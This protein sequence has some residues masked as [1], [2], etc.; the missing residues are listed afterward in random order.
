MDIH[1]PHGGDGSDD[2]ND[3]SGSGGGGG[4]ELTDDVPSLALELESWFEGAKGRNR[5]MSEHVIAEDYTGGGSG[6]GGATP[7]PPVKAGK[8]GRRR[9]G[10][11]R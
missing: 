4:G 8:R 10:G 2:D 9:R 5:L 7:D 3:N 6:G 1:L 11:R